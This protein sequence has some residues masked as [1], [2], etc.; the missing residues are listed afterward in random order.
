[1]LFL[2]LI[3]ALLPVWEKGDT[4]RSHIG[5]NPRCAGWAATQGCPYSIPALWECGRANRRARRKMTCR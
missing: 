3:P 1:M 5:L 2:P 4:T